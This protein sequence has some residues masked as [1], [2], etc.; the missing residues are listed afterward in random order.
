MSL[1]VDA[2]RKTLVP[3]PG[4]VTSSQKCASSGMS[5]DQQF[6]CRFLSFTRTSHRAEALPSEWP[7]VSSWD[8]EGAEAAFFETLKARGV[9]DLSPGRD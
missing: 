7:P 1:N 9:D 8:A 4:V 3:S 2:N 6:F 5:L